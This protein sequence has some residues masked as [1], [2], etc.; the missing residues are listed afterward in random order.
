MIRLL[1]AFVATGILVSIGCTNQTTTT[2]GQ[3]PTMTTGTLATKKVE[4]HHDD[5][6]NHER[7]KMMVAHCGPTVHVWLTAHLS[8]KSGNELDLFF[9]TEEDEKPLAV[10]FTKIVAKV[11]PTREDK[12]YDVVFEPAPASE[13]PKGEPADKC[14]HFVAKAPWIKADDTLFVQFELELDGK[15]RKSVWKSFEVKKYTHHNE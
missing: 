11:K 5:H 15:L 12:T 13:R 7:D 9:E 1:S 3:K 2:S 6:D 10:P 4:D 8:S 14:S